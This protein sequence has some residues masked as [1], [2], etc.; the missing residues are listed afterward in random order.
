[1]T[2]RKL[3]QYERFYPYLR[4]LA[5]F[6]LLIAAG[7]LVVWMIWGNRYSS[8]QASEL[9]FSEVQLQKFDNNIFATA[10]V[11]PKQS[12]ILSTAIE[13]RANRVF[14][15]AGQFLSK[16]QIVATL[17]NPQ[18]AMQVLEQE[19]RLLQQTDNVLQAQ[20]ALQALDQEQLREIKDLELRL[21]NVDDDLARNQE[22][23]HKG[24]VSESQYRRWEREKLNLE[25]TLDARSTNYAAQRKLLVRQIEDLEDSVN[26]IRNQ[27]ELAGAALES[28]TIRSSIDGVLTSLDIKVGEVISP[29]K[30]IG[31]V[32]NLGDVFLKSPVDE[33]FLPTLVKGSN[34]SILEG[35]NIYQGVLTD[36]G[37]NIVE[38]AVEARIEFIDFVP[39]GLAKG[40]SFAIR[41]NTGISREALGLPK[42]DFYSTSKDQQVY[43]VNAEDRVASL[44]NVSLR[45]AG[46]EQLEV[47]SGLREGD[48]VIVSSYAE[49]QPRAKIRLRGKLRP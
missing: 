14:V 44:K 23:L 43:V 27:I 13:G 45:D 17:E 31:S 8:M 9:R 1:M 7:L 25:Q 4:I 47:L 39:D 26:E 37:K 3:T 19:T 5:K 10:Q 33:Y 36:I 24:I 35:E 16:N 48:L 22:F 38:G 34:V 32:D 21:S 6:G 2:D 15:E 40:Q 46:S 18:Y 41:I 42:D 30:E 28:L 29:G 49:M 20:L 12:I 11:V